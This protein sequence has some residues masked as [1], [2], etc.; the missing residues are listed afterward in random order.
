M[1]DIFSNE[2]VY[3]LFSYFDTIN[4]EFIDGLNILNVEE[5][6]FRILK[7]R[8]FERILFYNGVDGLY[9]Y[10]ENSLNKKKTSLRKSLRSLRKDKEKELKLQRNMSEEEFIKNL[11]VYMKSKKKSAV[12]VTD[13]FSLLE[14]SS[15]NVLKELN[16]VFIDIK[17]LD[18][19]NEN[20]L[21]FLDPTNSKLNMIQER[22]SHIRG[23]SNL[24]TTIFRKLEDNER[25]KTTENVIFLDL[26]YKDEIR[27][28]LNVL[29]LKKDLKVNFLEFDDIVDELFRYSRQNKKNLKEIHI[30]I[31]DI[32]YIDLDSVLQAIGEKKDLKAWDKLNNLKGV[33]DIRDKIKSIV[34]TV[35]S[36]KKEVDTSFSTIKRFTKFDKAKDKTLINIVLTGNPGTG[37][38]TI[39]QIIGEIF[40]EEGILEGGQFIKVSK[41]DLVGQY[42]GETAIKTREKI[43]E[44]KGGILFIDEAYS[45]AEDEHFGREAINELVD[46]ITEYY[47]ELCVIVAGYPEEMENFLKSNEGLKS[48]FPYKIHIEDYTP[49]ILESIFDEK[50]K[51]LNLSDEVKSIK[52][53]YF[54]NFYKNRTKT[55]GNARFIDVLVNTLESNML[56]NNRD[57]IDLDD[58]TD[59]F[60]EFL[61]PKYKKSVDSSKILEKLDNYVGFDDVKKDLRRIFNTILVNKKKNKKVLPPHIALLGN[62]GTGKTTVAEIIYSFFKEVGLLKGDFIKV[63]RADLVAGYVGQSAIKTREVLEKAKGGVLFIDE[64]YDLVN[65]ENDFGKEVVTEIMDYME[66]NRGDISVIF[67][68]YKDLTLKFFET[69]PG[70]KS[71]IDAYIYL[72]DYT[73]KELLEIFQFMLKERNLK[74]TDKALEKVKQFIDD[75]VKNKDKNFANAR[76]VRKL[77]DRFETNLNDRVANMDNFEKIDE[78]DEILYTLTEED[79]F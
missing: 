36:K 34:K 14:H 26:P 1:K 60:R 27:N 30:K 76:E 3:F 37:K 11:E 75:L 4:D 16:Q 59:E 6:I 63:K 22:L 20:V 48:R 78:N 72:R 52:K 17:Q 68:G 54:Q 39:A 13:L 38:S 51:H 21:I 79:I 35:K 12:I 41:S 58:F 2:R 50:T 32:S 64:A 62:P 8:G 25:L 19:E 53:E 57:Y 18:A 10:D 71:R 66:S 7:K 55:S 29:R 74:I 28:L 24:T 44:A 47:S 65:G 46:A 43:E 69:N 70:L 45:L 61:P 9:A 31:K 40:K 15:V 56:L 5:M 67:A 73:S 49:D 42:I 23:I 77:L 33:E